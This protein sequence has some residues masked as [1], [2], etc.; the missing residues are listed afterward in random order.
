VVVFYGRKRIIFFMEENMPLNIKNTEA[1]R[2]A[3]DLA[4]KTG[5]T[6]TEAVIKALRERLMRHEGRSSLLS[7]ETELM[8]I[9]RRCAALPDLDRRTA[10]EILGYNDI[11]VPDK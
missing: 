2:L 10:D 3:H 1:D 4:A 8:N 9:G 5:E 7:L 6:I 11:G